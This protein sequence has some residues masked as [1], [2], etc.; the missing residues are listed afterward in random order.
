MSK[1]SGVDDVGPRQAPSSE[2]LLRALVRTLSTVAEPRQARGIRHPLVNVLTIAVLGCMCRCDD[3]E[4]IEDWGQKEAD[5][6]SD[7]L[8]MPH[9]VP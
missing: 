5:W 9:G 8:D 3:A 4:A 2:S 7:F 6:L 1:P